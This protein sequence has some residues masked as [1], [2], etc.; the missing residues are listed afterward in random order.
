MKATVSGLIRV[1]PPPIQYNGFR[2]DFADWRIGIQELGATR[3]GNPLPYAFDFS[4]LLVSD[5][6][7]TVP[8]RDAYKT[9]FPAWLNQFYTYSPGTTQPIRT[10]GLPEDNPYT[11]RIQPWT[12]YY[13]TAGGRNVAL[14]FPTQSHA[15]IPTLTLVNPQSVAAAGNGFTLSLTGTNF[16]SSSIVLWAGQ[17]HPTTYVSPTQLTALISAA[18]IANSGSASVAVFNP[19]LGGGLSNS[20]FVAIG[21]PQLA[22][23][24]IQSIVRDAAGITIVALVTN[25]G[26]GPA[27]NIRFTSLK[28]GTA[29]PLSNGIL[30]DLIPGQITTVQFIF[31]NNA[32]AAGAN[33]FLRVNGTYAG[34]SFTTSRRVLLP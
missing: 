4:E 13:V 17:Q 31:P 3:I 1:T 25:I 14:I 20:I 19:A 24:G 12:G 7:K 26:T 27:S 9:V 10:V 21:I 16:T 15:V 8:I 34:G 22:V 23:T 32:G 6:I 18:D 29:N 33:V 11:T 5:G 2:A 28:L 30:P